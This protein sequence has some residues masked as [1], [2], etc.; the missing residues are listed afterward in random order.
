[1]SGCS[2]GRRHDTT[3]RA[4]GWQNQEMK[5]VC[6]VRE[7]S[8]VD[9]L[10]SCHVMCLVVDKARAKLCWM[11]S[12][13]DIEINM[14]VPMVCNVFPISC[15]PCCSPAFVFQNGSRQAELSCCYSSSSRLQTTPLSCQEMTTISRGVPGAQS[16][17]RQLPHLQLPA[18]PPLPPQGGVRP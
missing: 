16:A 12:A 10:M 2:S 14:P 8:F 1:M 3:F 5:R 9:A 6:R 13:A 15:M 17:N 18:A 4:L 7:Q 11:S